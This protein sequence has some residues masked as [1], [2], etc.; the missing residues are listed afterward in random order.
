MVVKSVLRREGLHGKQSSNDRLYSKRKGGS[1]E[2]KSFK[3][4]YAE[5]KTKVSCYMIAK[6]NG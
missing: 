2:L 4:V 6:T 3:E 5:T 1:I